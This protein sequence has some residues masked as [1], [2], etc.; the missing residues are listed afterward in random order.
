MTSHAAAALSCLPDVPFGLTQAR[1]VG[2]AAQHECRRVHR[3]LPAEGRSLMTVSRRSSRVNWLRILPVA[4]FLVGMM[5]GGLLIGLT[6]DDERSAAAPVEQTPLTAS[7]G[8]SPTPGSSDTTV[9]VPA[10]CAEAVREVELAVEL[11]QEGASAVRDVQPE[12][13]VRVLNSLEDTQ[14]RLEQ[15]TRACSEIEVKPGS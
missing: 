11:M 1:T 6:R 4:T 13:L 12:E 15:L 2:G 9:T 8:T 3:C 14:A 10:A 7:P 5:L